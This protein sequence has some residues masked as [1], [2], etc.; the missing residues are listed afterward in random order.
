MEL[1]FLKIDFTSPTLRYSNVI[2]LRLLSSLMKSVVFVLH[3]SLNL[4][5]LVKVNKEVMEC[6]LTEVLLRLIKGKLLL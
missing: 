3:K 6:N 1:Q 5:T 2:K 4:T